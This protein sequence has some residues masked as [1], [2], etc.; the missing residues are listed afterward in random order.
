[1]LK[2]N[3][4]KTSFYYSCIPYNSNAHL[5]SIPLGKPP[6][7]DVECYSWWSHKMRTYL[8]S[9]HTSIWNVVENGMQL[10]DSDDENYNAIDVQESIHKNAQ[11]TTVLLASLCK[12]YNKVS[13]LDNAKEI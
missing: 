10:L 9:I 2:Q 12:H 4:P 6:N 7:F 5:L 8:F 1:M 3:Y 13:G 11:A